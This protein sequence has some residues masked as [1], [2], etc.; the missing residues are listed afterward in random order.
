MARRRYN[1]LPIRSSSPAPA[2]MNCGNNDEM[3]IAMLL[4]R[5]KNAKRRHWLASTMA[6]CTWSY[7]AA[8]LTV[9]LLLWLGGDRWWFPTVILFGPRWLFALPLV[10][11]APLALLMRRR[12]LWVLFAAAIV[13]FGPLMGF[14]A[15]WARM[16]AA[17]GPS[18]RILTCN[19]K[20]KCTNNQTLDELINK[21]SP[22]IVALQGC[23]PD[24]QVRWPAGWHTWKRGEFVVASRYPLLSRGTKNR[25]G[26]SEE[27]P[28]AG[29]VHCIVQTPDRDIDLFSTHLHSPRNGLRS[30][31]DRETLLQPS[32]GPIL[33]ADIERRSRESANAEHWVR[34]FSGSPI[35][36]GDFNMSTGSRIYRR[37]WAKY[38]N[39]FSDAGLGYGYT[40][41]PQ[42]RGF[43]WGVRIDHVLMGPGWGCRSCWV[44]PDIGSDHLPL[45]AE[46]SLPTAD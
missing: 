10:V 40:E 16:A 7:V 14:R 42:I 28:Q 9:W 31:L 24:V 2:A 6:F 8:V 30:V 39:A 25:V 45:L 23:W 44:G 13:V 20:G 26:P 33:E 15:S 35:L 29:M 32:D 4:G 3:P 46:L 12:L 37:D 17:S 34:G 27:W 36:V 19:V 38:R 18:L 22:D 41:W 43:S 21:T 5:S 11:L 1:F